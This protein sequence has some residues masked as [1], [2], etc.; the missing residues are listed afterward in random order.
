MIE[1]KKN[2]SKVKNGVEIIFREK[3]SSPTF[4]PGATDHQAP[5]LPTELFVG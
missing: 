3:W 1:G 2:T 5:G 4:K